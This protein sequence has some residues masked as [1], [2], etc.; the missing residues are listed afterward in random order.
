MFF[1]CM[2]ALAASQ[3]RVK[4]AGRLVAGALAAL[5][6]FGPVLD[7]PVGQGALEADVVAGPF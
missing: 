2:A 7:D 1:V 6:P 3:D 4:G 5:P